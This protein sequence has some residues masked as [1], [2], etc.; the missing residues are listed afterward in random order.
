ML[1]NNFSLRIILFVIVI[2]LT[3][4]GFAWSVQQEF[5][6]ATS[7]GLGMAII[8]ETIALVY[9]LTR[10]KNDLKNFIESIKNEDTSLLFSHKSGNKFYREI[11]RGFNE[12]MSD[13]KLVRK[14]KELERH[15]FQNTVEHVNVGL[16]AVTDQGD[17][18]M[19]NNALKELTG[20]TTLSTLKTLATIH[21]ELPELLFAMSNKNEQSIKIY[22]NRELKTVSIKA[23]IFKMDKERIHIFSFQDISKQINRS[24]I[25]AWQKLIQVLRH[26]I[27]NSISPIRIMSGNL[28]NLANKLDKLPEN[29]TAF[30]RK[31]IPKLKEGLQT[32][33]KRSAG[34]GDFVE[35]YRSLTKIP[36]P[37]FVKIQ[38]NELLK[39]VFNL[40]HDQ[41]S[42]KNITTETAVTPQS[43][44]VM[45]DE[46][47]LVQVLL[48]TL[49][50]AIEAIGNQQHGHI[51][52]TAFRTSD[53]VVITMQDNG[54]GIPPE[55]QE[56]I[57][58]PFFT[59]K[60]EGSGI[61]LSFSRQVMH[62]HGGS[63]DIR[64]EP[65]KGTEVILTL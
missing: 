50:N 27:M 24:E 62:L 19:V 41:L 6:V 22:S 45:G 16:L 43:L 44:F 29:D 5:M 49:K 15:F 54:P 28:L 23:S 25:E 47:M 65:G 4:L 51:Q 53:E 34:L 40:M 38:I 30:E 2:V 48:N 3:G 59:T 31:D 33:R 11:Y 12:I 56:H 20:I 8:I 21:P 58:V 13:F 63:I 52:L 64:S 1:L 60:A 55:Q 10:V 9:F 61:G 7:A 37:S 26:E 39:H 42:N 32:I 14:E 36:E 46:K 18:K 17:I 35:K 57:F